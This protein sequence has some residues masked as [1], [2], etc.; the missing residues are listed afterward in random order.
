LWYGFSL[1]MCAPYVPADYGSKIENVGKW[2][3]TYL[4]TNLTQIPGR[5]KA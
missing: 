5:G 1:G 3:S 2:G 4:E